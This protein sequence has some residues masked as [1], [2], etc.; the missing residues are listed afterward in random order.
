MA[1]ERC[2][3]EEGHYGE[4]DEEEDYPI[5][6]LEI[7]MINE[8]TDECIELGLDIYCQETYPNIPIES[9]LGCLSSFYTP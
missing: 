2:A 8:L 6:E 9:F 3:A 1:A 4:A 7:C 5:D